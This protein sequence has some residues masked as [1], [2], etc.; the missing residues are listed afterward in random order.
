MGED[1]YVG[2]AQPARCPVI[3]VYRRAGR[4][5]AFAVSSR[6]ST[7]ALRAARAGAILRCC[8]GR[9]ARHQ[10]ANYVAR[11][12]RTYGCCLRSSWRRGEAPPCAADGGDRG[13]REYRAVPARRRY[14]GAR[15]GPAA[16]PGRACVVADV[17]RVG[18]FFF[19][20]LD[21]NASMRCVGRD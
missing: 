5:I 14:R 21:W 8:R 3:L 18:A 19:S 17:V 15:Q 16:R 7:I 10:F 6:R 11:P 1:R 12:P 9:R 13:P 20:G 4:S 2:A